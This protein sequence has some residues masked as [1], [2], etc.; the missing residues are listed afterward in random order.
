MVFFDSILL[1]LWCMMTSE[2]IVYSYKDCRP[3]FCVVSV[4]K[5][6]TINIMH[7]LCGLVTGTTTNEPEMQENLY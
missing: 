6:K 2:E 4:K 7:Y 3:Y 1:S 5:I